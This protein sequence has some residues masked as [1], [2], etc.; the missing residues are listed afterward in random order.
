LEAVG[1]FDEAF[2]MAWRED[3]DLQFKFLLAGIPI[4][5]IQEAV[6]VHPVRKA[7]W[8]VSLKEQKKTMF[9][10]LLYKKYPSLYKEKI[11]TTPPWHYYVIVISFFLFLISETFHFNT[12]AYAS[13]FSWLTLTLWFSAKRLQSTRRTILHIAEMVVTSIL[14]PFIS[15]YW[16]HYGSYKYKVLLW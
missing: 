5:R 15:L 1:G 6:V 11:Q 7:P 12:L 2:R 3:S 9:N 4:T 10:A 13:F 8:G 14:I 16:R